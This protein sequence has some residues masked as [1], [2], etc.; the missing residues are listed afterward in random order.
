[1]AFYWYLCIWWLFHHFFVTTQQTIRQ[2]TSIKHIVL[3][4]TFVRW[5][6]PGAHD[7]LYIFYCTS[8]FQND[9]SFKLLRSSNFYLHLSA[10][11]CYTRVKIK[12][13]HFGT[14]DTYI[15]YF[16]VVNELSNYYTKKKTQGF[17]KF[18]SLLKFVRC[19]MLKMSVLELTGW[20][21]DI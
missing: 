20:S 19:S 6:F 18:L 9:V 5:L 8:H 15:A 10:Y 11:Y 21:R 14:L 2:C 17:A 13:L 7:V 12:H 16:I 4:C 1:M 3:Q